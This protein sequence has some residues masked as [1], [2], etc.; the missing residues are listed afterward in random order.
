M[1]NKRELDW[2]V[3]GYIVQ[4]QRLLLIHHRKL[5]KWLPP[6]GH[7][8]ENETPDEALRR[9]IR[10]EAGLEVE[11]VHYPKPRRGNNR[12]YAT[13]FY[14]NVHHITSNHLHYCLFYLLRP[15][16]KT[17]K[18]RKSEL[19]DAK[20]VSADDLSHLNPPLNDGDL[21]TCLEA[22]ELSRGT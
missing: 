7:P 11:F 3:A 4:D 18:L 6:G 12:Q 17:L 20:W 21:A 15:R 19:K 1:V 5:D 13:P 2:V 10:E 22:I 8:E 16:S 9:E 14:Q